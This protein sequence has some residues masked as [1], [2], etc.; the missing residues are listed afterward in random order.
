MRCNNCSNFE[1]RVGVEAGNE[2]A[3]DIRAVR[4][5]CSI[6]NRDCMAT[7]KC[8]CGGYARK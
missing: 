5:S 7:D 1:R 2:I 4:G 6:N 8:S 3:P